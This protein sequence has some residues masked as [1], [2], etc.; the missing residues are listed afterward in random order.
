MDTFQAPIIKTTEENI[1]F[2]MTDERT[3]KALNYFQKL[4]ND[5][6]VIYPYG[7]S[8]RIEDF[9]KG[10]IAMMFSS[11]GYLSSDVAEDKTGIMY[12]PKTLEKEEYMVPLGPGG[13]ITGF[14]IT[15]KNPEVLVEIYEYI[16][17]PE[18]IYQLIEEEGRY[19]ADA[20]DYEFYQEMLG[21]VKASSYS[22]SIL[23]QK[24]WYDE[25]SSVAVQKIIEGLNEIL[26]GKSPE[27]KMNQIS[28]NIQQILNEISY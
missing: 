17:R 18:D 5:E 10:N 24:L 27:K 21:E 26:E 15:A 20:S 19:L 14:S 11:M 12:V 23:N 1:E 9:K 16:F 28:P 25:E 22:Q 7:F 4:F 6:E 3:I 8:E 13:M 2:A